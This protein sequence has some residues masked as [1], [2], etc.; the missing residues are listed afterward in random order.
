MR[1]KRSRASSCRSGYAL[2]AIFSRSSAYSSHSSLGFLAVDDNS[3]IIY[4]SLLLSG[5]NRW[6]NAFFC[7][8]KGV[9]LSV[10]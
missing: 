7:M 2:S 9:F 6:R 1:A 3:A 4:C 10:S 5:S 8:F